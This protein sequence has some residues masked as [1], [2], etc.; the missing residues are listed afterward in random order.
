MIK[1]VTTKQTNKFLPNYGKFISKLFDLEAI[2]NT[3]QE[4]EQN[5]LNFLEWNTG[6]FY[7]VF[8]H[9][10]IIAMVRRSPYNI[11]DYQYFRLENGLEQ[12]MNIFDAKSDKEAIEK[13]QIWFNQYIA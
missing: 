11:G 12:G 7:N 6:T 13:A 8:Q 1:P 3:K 4:A 9:N 10:S 2:G 5:L